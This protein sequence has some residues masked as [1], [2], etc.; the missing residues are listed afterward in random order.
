MAHVSTEMAHDHIA[1]ALY[2]FTSKRLCSFFPPGNK[3]QRSSN[4]S[5]ELAHLVLSSR[6]EQT[7]RLPFVIRV[8]TD[9]CQAKKC[10][11]KGK[12]SGQEEKLT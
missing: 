2:F 3:I 4:I 1:T 5:H 7:R 9:F 8:E 11:A 10:K 6:S 12:A